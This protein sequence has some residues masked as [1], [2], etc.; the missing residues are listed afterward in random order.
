M[1]MTA[2]SHFMF[3]RYVEFDRPLGITPPR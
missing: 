2:A 3:Q 1:R